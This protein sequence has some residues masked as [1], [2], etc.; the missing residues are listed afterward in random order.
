MAASLLLRVFLCHSSEDKAT[1]RQLYRRLRSDGFDP[2]LD[3][4]NLLPGQDW[5]LEIQ[6]AVRSAHVVLVCLS[7]GSITKAG[8]VQ[9]EIK[10]ALDVADEQPE[11]TIFLIPV[12][13]EECQVPTRLGR[14]QWLNLH[15][16]GGYER[17]IQAL[18]LRAKDLH[19]TVNSMVTESNFVAPST[20]SWLFGRQ[21][22]S[23]TDDAITVWNEQSDSKVYSF[24]DLLQAEISYRDIITSPNGSLVA[25]LVSTGVST[26]LTHV[27]GRDEYRNRSKLY[28]FAND[29]IEPKFVTSDD[30]FVHG[31]PAFSTD[32]KS[33]AYAFSHSWR[34]SKMLLGEQEYETVDWDE[35]VAI[36]DTN[37]W[38]VHSLWSEQSL[39]GYGRWAEPE[40]FTDLTFIKH[41]TALFAIS[42]KPR[43][44][45][46]AWNIPLDGSK[47]I[48]VPNPEF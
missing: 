15:G 7:Q 44:V 16:S 10:Y 39:N 42:V 29:T 18:G 8:Y 17:L 46:Q 27:D 40:H 13:L 12:K 14:W 41:D 11:G 30:H 34:P 33:I 2:W 37:N 38:Q 31:G 35:T 6:K 28:I 22:F 26:F 36:I 47:P 24:K 19:I 25:V 21:W 4:E 3:E 9:R 1:V 43:G 23:V 20:F 45:S 48:I 5:H 32:N